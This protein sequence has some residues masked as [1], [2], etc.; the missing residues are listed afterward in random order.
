MYTISDTWV[1][2]LNNEPQMTSHINIFLFLAR[3]AYSLKVHL[4]LKLLSVYS[5]NAALRNFKIITHQLVDC[6]YVKGPW[7]PLWSTATT[8]IH[9][10]RICVYRVT[11]LKNLKNQIHLLSIWI[12]N[13]FWWWNSDIFYEYFDINFYLWWNIIKNVT[14]FNK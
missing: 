7:L 13:V 2:F 12:S 10:F 8:S 4:T 6:K 1:D 14:L 11:K 3:I 5:A 9:F